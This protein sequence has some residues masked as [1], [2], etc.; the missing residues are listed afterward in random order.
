[1]IIDIE[2]EAVYNGLKGRANQRLIKATGSNL[3]PLEPIKSKLP[4]STRAL[5]EKPLRS[6]LKKK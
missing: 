2:K 1:M 4:E 3:K 6:G 5:K